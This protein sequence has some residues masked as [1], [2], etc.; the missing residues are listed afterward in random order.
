M[1]IEN[2][3]KPKSSLG[4]NEDLEKYYAGLETRKQLSDTSAAPAE[5]LLVGTVYEQYQE[6]L[7]GI[8]QDAAKSLREEFAN[9]EK[10]YFSDKEVNKSR[11]E[12]I[13]RIAAFTEHD[14]A[15][16]SAIESGNIEGHWFTIN[17][18][19]VK[20]QFQSDLGLQN[21]LIDEEIKHVV[22]K[23]EDETLYG[24]RGIATVGRH[25]GKEGFI[26]PEGKYIYTHD[27]DQFMV[28]SNIEQQIEQKQS[29]PTPQYAETEAP[30]RSFD[31]SITVLDDT[32]SIPGAKMRVQLAS[33]QDRWVMGSSGAVGVRRYLQGD[34]GVCGQVGANPWNF[35][36]NFNSYVW[37]QISHFKKPKE[38]VLVGI[39]VNALYGK[40]K[41]RRDK[42]MRGYKELVADLESKGF[43]V[44]IATLV[45]AKS[46]EKQVIAFNEMLRQEFPNRI[47]DVAKAVGLPDG[48]VR[49][50]YFASDKVH[51]RR[52]AKKIY[53][54][55][56]EGR[57]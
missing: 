23:R 35:R 39:G 56:I 54:S 53:A 9:K 10:E 49:P 25:K 22:V 2:S 8:N 7:A 24:T 15:S 51:L 16:L 41:A 33:G 17:Y 5:D 43:N 13:K 48:R 47:R 18:S 21:I 36:R 31:R 26:T 12:G 40:S 57:A 37:P 42:V 11:E 50:E 45:A 1:S 20:G 28:S 3:Q 30:Q 6:K 44:K 52:P 38:I 29:L 14:P 34:S 32:I 19:Q 55:V 4:I 27:G 46:R